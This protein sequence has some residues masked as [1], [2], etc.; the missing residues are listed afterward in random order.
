[1]EELPDA[2]SCRRWKKTAM[3]QVASATLYFMEA[4]GWIRDAFEFENV[5]AESLANSGKF[6]RLDL[7][8]AADLTKKMNAICKNPNRRHKIGTS[9]ARVIVLTLARSKRRCC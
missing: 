4:V 7:M 2:A 8:A 1:M 9:P 6:E 3:R 5:A